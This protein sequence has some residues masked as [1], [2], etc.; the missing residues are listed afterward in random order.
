MK[1]NSLSKL[2]SD[3][4]IFGIGT[5]LAKVIQFAL[6][7]LYTSYMSTEAYG[8]AELVNN[9]S[10]LFLPIVSL[11]LYD[12][13]LRF[14]IEKKSNE[15]VISSAIRVL[16]FSFGISIPVFIIAYL[17]WKSTYIFMLE[18]I[19]YA[20]SIQRFFAC[21]VRGKGYS[22][23]YALSG[24]VNALFVAVFSIYYLVISNS[25]IEGYLMAIALGYFSSAIYLFCAGKIY[26]DIKWKKTS[27]MVI[28]EMIS[29]SA[30][31]IP[32]NI[33]YF[34]LTL[35]GR[36]I[37]LWIKGE[38]AVGLY[39]AAMKISAI[40]NVFQQAVST[41]LQLNVSLEYSSENREKYYSYIFDLF[42]SG[43]WVMASWVI[44]LC[45]LLA[46]ILLK[47]EFYVARAY[48]PIIIFVAILNCLSAM[49]GT[50]FQAYKLTKKNVPIVF[51]GMI[52]NI[53]ICFI[54]VPRHGIWGVCIASLFS[55]LGQIIMK[56]KCISS[57][58]T[59][60]YD[61]KNMITFPIVVIA[62][63]IV[64]IMFNSMHLYVILI[65]ASI[66]E[67]FYFVY[68]YLS[69]LQIIRNQLIAKLFK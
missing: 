60:N 16:G 6:L 45:P 24:A 2:F 47:N 43:Y 51:T 8:I 30:P 49:Y 27:N 23:V 29:F 44:C 67:M 4:V 11:C 46:K 57:F 36:Y 38:D 7:P 37:L 12:A 31:L 15:I 52:I 68:T 28:N 58:C 20:Y 5:V 1:A 65:I 61:W 50:M 17:I 19:V 55:Y 64:S 10:E 13:V 9:L 69:E 35:A 63:L 42:Y 54:L 14:T 21:Y 22:R 40:I 32:F 25:G 26:K 33:M 18:F 3:I 53:A 39:S 34:F 56:I 62:Q 59:I 41:A 66:I 48:L